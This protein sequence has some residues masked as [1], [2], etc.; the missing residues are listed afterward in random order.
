M[1]YSSCKQVGVT[2]PKGS[3]E[4]HDAAGPR[5]L[6]W[7]PEDSRRVFGAT[8]A[9]VGWITSTCPASSDGSETESVR[10]IESSREGWVKTS[11]CA[12][13]SLFALET[14]RVI[15]N[16]SRFGEITVGTRPFADAKA[17]KAETV[18]ADG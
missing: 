3:L 17:S 10:V 6:I 4:L 9:V 5:T 18:S 2:T 13:K 7:R 16:Q 11:N 12:A 8:N 1:P 15:E 14:G